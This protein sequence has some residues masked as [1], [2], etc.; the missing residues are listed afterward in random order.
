ME[1]AGKMMHKN[2]FNVTLYNRDAQLRSQAGKFFFAI[3]EGQN[4]S[5]Q[6]EWIKFWA[7]QAKKKLTRAT[8]GPRDV[9]C[10][11]MLYNVNNAYTWDTRL[12]L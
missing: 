8:F 6:A 11:R 9:F 7:L 3:S 4:S 1:N 10:A 5:K 2:Y 12:L